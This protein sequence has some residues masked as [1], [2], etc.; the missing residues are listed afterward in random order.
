MDDAKEAPRVRRES[1]VKKQRDLQ[2]THPRRTHLAER[3][4]LEQELSD[5]RTSTS[6]SERPMSASVGPADIGDKGMLGGGNARMPVYPR[7]KPRPSV[8][9]APP[10]SGKRTPPPLFVVIAASVYT[11]TAPVG[12]GLRPQGQVG[13]SATDSRCLCHGKPVLL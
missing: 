5:V 3:H 13:V 12:W 10:V 6:T 4:S 2:G 11:V 8:T 9:D 1:S 7:E